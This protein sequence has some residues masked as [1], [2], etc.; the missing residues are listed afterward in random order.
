[1]IDFLFQHWI[2]LLYV[3]IAT[4]SLVV[5]LVKKTKLVTEDTIFEQLIRVLPK[6][7]IGAEKTG[8]KGIDKKDIVVNVA[9]DWLVNM[10]GKTRV[11]LAALYSKRIEDAIEDILSTPEKK[12]D[13]L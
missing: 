10:T 13:I 1:M 5:A 9:L 12:G 6:M 11:D 7:I 3:V 8:L 4:A 2:E